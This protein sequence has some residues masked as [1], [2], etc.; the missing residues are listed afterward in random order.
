MKIQ[1][2]SARQYRQLKSQKTGE[3]Y[4]L[5]S[6]ISEVLQPKDIFC[7]QEIVR[8]NSRSSAPHFHTEVDEIVYVLKGTLKAIEGDVEVELNEGDSIIFQSNSRQHHYLKN[9]L[10]CEAQILV[11]RKNIENSDVNF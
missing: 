2:N 7:S 1:K 11:I 4:S 8:P 3:E 5:S 10:N 6:V 9:E